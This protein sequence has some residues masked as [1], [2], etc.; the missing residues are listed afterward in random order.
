MAPMKITE[1]DP[2]QEI[3]VEGYLKKIR[4]LL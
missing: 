3:I 4:A 1:G 2:E